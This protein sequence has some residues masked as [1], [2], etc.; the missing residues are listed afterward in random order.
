LYLDFVPDS[1]WTN[2]Y[3]DVASFKLEK[4]FQGIPD[5][6]QPEKAFSPENKALPLALRKDIRENATKE[7]DNLTRIDKASGQ[8]GWSFNVEADIVAL[9]N[10]I[11]SG[12][13]NRLGEIFADYTDNVAQLFEREMKDDMVKDTFLEACPKKS[14]IARQ[15]KVKPE[16]QYILPKIENQILY[17]DFV[18]D[19]V[20]TNIYYDVASFK[21]EKLL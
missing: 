8:T 2:I 12:Y 21:L 20:W 16:G 7:F 18:P 14:I 1:V 4:L 15:V 10:G 6:K 19:S 13:K 17:L 9:N 3:Y 5:F 11:D